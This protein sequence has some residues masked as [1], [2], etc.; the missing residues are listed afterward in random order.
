MFD[1]ENKL[2]EIYTQIL[3]PGD[4]AID[5]GAHTGRHTLPMLACV[6]PGGE[7][8]AFEP[9]PW[10]SNLLES[11]ISGSGRSHMAKRF[12]MALADRPHHADFELV[13]ENPAYSGLRERNY[14]TPVTRTRIQVEVETLDRLLSKVE[15]MRFIKIDCEG[16][17]LLAL[18]G[19]VDS[20]ARFQP[21]ISIESGDASLTHYP[22]TSADLYDF[23]HALD[24]RIVNLHGVL[25]DRE[26]FIL[27]NQQ[28]SYWDYLAIPAASDISIQY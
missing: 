14:D 27:A 16:A 18:R 6:D 12:E 8:W 19:A 2:Q 23:L 15:H 26:A 20:I 28:Q 25:H 22:Y 13:N 10:I 21:Y 3:R 5:I 7:V 4:R 17:E 24:Y 11:Q 1:N 9:I